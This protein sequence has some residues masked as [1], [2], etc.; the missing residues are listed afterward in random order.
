MLTGQLNFEEIQR[1]SPREEAIVL[2]AMH[3]TLVDC[4]FCLTKETDAEPL[5][6]FPSYFN[7]ERRAQIDDPRV[8][9]T[10]RFSG[11][12]KELYGT[13]VVKLHHTRAFEKGELWRYEALLIAIKSLKWRWTSSLRRACP[14]C[15]TELL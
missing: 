13:L 7:R 15:V 11:A 8:F 4:G 6:V 9:G 3:Q 12:L 10:F 1:L 5:L 2:R 14:E